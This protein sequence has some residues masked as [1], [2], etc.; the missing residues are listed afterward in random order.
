MKIAGMA[1]PFAG[2]ESEVARFDLQLTDQI[3]L[4][5]LI[6][7]RNGRGELRVFAPNLRGVNCVNFRA[8]LAEE[9]A[10]LAIEY[11]NTHAYWRA[12][13]HGFVDA[14]AA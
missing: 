3:K 13:A 8:D 9:I 5:G 6:L 14:A 4:N 12:P 7:R 1:P 2:R 10:R 11:Y